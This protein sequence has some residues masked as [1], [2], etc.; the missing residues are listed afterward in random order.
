MYEFNYGMGGAGGTATYTMFYVNQRQGA[1]CTN[2]PQPAYLPDDTPVGCCD[3]EGNACYVVSTSGMRPV[4]EPPNLARYGH[5][6]G[7]G[8][9]PW[10]GRAV[11]RYSIDFPG[12]PDRPIVFH[13][14]PESGFGLGFEHPGQ[15]FPDPPA[16]R[17]EYIRRWHDYE[18][19]FV[20]KFT[21]DPMQYWVIL[22]YR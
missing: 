10:A 1:Y 18:R 7:G 8:P 15:G 20:V 5:R 6:L 16:G 11:A 2:N 9:P 3:V 4:T 19:G 21:N 22:Y 12:F 14:E 17:I 13:K